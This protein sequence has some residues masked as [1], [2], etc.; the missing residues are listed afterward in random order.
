MLRLFYESFKFKD[1]VRV[2][3]ART[4]GNNW[5]SLLLATTTVELVF[6]PAARHGCGHLQLIRGSRS[7]TRHATMRLPGDS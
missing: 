7:A 4:D 6:P 3:Q 1:L 5:L 2:A